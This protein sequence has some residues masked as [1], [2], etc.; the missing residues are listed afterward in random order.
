MTQRPQLG[1]SGCQAVT[2]IRER[3]ELGRGAL[4]GSRATQQS[5]RDRGRWMMPPPL[6]LLLELLLLVVSPE[7]CSG[8]TT[9][10]SAAATRSCWAPSRGGVSTSSSQQH[11]RELHRCAGCR[12]DSPHSESGRRR[13]LQ[14]VAAESGGFPLHSSSC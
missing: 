14:A 8:F 1:V 12:V 13:R 4:N 9:G 2:G 5:A 6:L 11:G 3:K 10:L 7:L